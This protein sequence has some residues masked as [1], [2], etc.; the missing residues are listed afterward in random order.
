MKKN[1]LFLMAMVAA[2]TVYAQDKVPDMTRFSKAPLGPVATGRSVARTIAPRDANGVPDMSRF[3]KAPVN[4]SGGST[5]RSSLRKGGE[6]TAA[7][8]SLPSNQPAANKPVAATPAT[9]PVVL[10]QEQQ[11]STEKH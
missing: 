6:G 4:K 7:P 2:F 9:V 3:S 1:I 5:M 11:S 8:A 10:E